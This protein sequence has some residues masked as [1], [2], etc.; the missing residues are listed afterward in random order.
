MLSP[1]QKRHFTFWIK[2]GPG[3]KFGLSERL[4]EILIKKVKSPMLLLTHLVSHS[5]S[6]P[7][8]S[9]IIPSLLTYNLPVL[10]ILSS[11]DYWLLSECPHGLAWIFCDNCFKFLVLNWD[12]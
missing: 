7:L 8:S 4:S 12:C 6:S 3:L 11:V 5:R 9:S 2:L 10:Q 1:N